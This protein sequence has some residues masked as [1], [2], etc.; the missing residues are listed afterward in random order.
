MRRRHLG[1]ALSLL[2]GALPQLGCQSLS[3]TATPPQAAP[4][5]AFE[6][7]LDA[8]RTPEEAA[9]T[10]LHTAEVFD[11]NGREAEAIQGYEM[12]RQANP[13][14]SN[15]LSRRLAVL[16]D[17]QGN[18]TKASE[19]YAKALQAYPKDSD[20]LNDYGYFLYQQEKYQEAEATL[21]KAVQL[22]PK[23][24][25]AVV[26]RGMAIGQQ[27][28]YEDA[29]N[30][31]AGAVGQAEAHA[32]LGYIYT[33]QGK[34]EEAINAYRQ[35][36]M[37]NPNL[38]QAQVAL[39]FYAKPPSDSFK[40]PQRPVAAQPSFTRPTPNQRPDDQFRPA[41]RPVAT[42]ERSPE[43]AFQRL[44]TFRQEHENDE[45]IQ[46]AKRVE[47]APAEQTAKPKSA[48]YD[49]AAEREAA[50]QEPRRFVP[51]VRPIT[52]PAPSSS[53]NSQD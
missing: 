43:A 51:S 25:R 49:P 40:E 28:R 32:N 13:K 15:Q 2:G 10:S 33:T 24:R 23:N 14:L 22:N 16:Y 42:R 18:V 8:P 34:R 45:A 48:L 3:T 39:E 47:P 37:L 53:G 21:V 6:R 46:A 17:R 29:F 50:P 19:E 52:I 9:R 20:L 12:A 30:V 27:G 41:E 35:A 36:L 11:K 44:S 38:K 5:I 31:F 7:P 4:A 26:N 1:L